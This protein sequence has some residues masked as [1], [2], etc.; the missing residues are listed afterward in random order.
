M[1]MPVYTAQTP[2][3]FQAVARRVEIARES[4]SVF[5]ERETNLAILQATTG[6]PW[7]I[8]YYGGTSDPLGVTWDKYG[9][10]ANGNPVC[11]Y[12]NFMQSAD[13]ALTLVPENTR[14][15]LARDTRPDSKIGYGARWEAVIVADHTLA[16]SGMPNE[17][18][19]RAILSAVLRYHAA[20]LQMAQKIA[21]TG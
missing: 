3:N 1:S 10:D 15:T 5:Q 17:S 20:R 14:I 12:Q 21:G 18:L 8:V 13:E 7:S 11:S 4:D 6:R 19:P 16:G 2:E 9:P